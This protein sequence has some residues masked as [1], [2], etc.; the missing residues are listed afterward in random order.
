MKKL[1]N[2]GL[3]EFEGGMNSRAQIIKSIETLLKEIFYHN[4]ANCEEWS[5]EEYEEYE[6]I[7]FPPMY[8]TLDQAIELDLETNF[9]D[10]VK[11]PHLA[12][13]ALNNLQ[14]E[15]P[16]MGEIGISDDIINL[17]SPKQ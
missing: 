14:P 6:E 10:A 5:E 8:M 15:F 9:M 4:E 13:K 17:F 2:E 12:K 1:V 3:Y 11:Y 16:D 7:G